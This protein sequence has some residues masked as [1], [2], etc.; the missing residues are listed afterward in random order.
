MKRGPKPGSSTVNFPAKAAAAWGNQM[1]PEI[2]ALAL[3]CAE[4][5]AS[6]VA[7]QLG[8]SPAVVSH[9]LA[10]KYPGDVEAVFIRIRGAL[11]G[12]EVQCPVLGLIGKDQCAREQRRP[13]SGA[14]PARARLHRACP[15]CP[16]HR[17]ATGAA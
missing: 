6:A 3:A 10:R 13:R 7:R 5:S 15:L 4:S 9:V 11:L 2:K 8:Y 17:S 16:N 14:N 12:E 1:P